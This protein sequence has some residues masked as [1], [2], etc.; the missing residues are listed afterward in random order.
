MSERPRHEPDEDDVRRARRGDTD[1]LERLFVRYAADLRAVVDREGS[2][3]LRNEVR[4]SD[5]L[6]STYIAVLRDIDRFEGVSPRAFLGWAKKILLNTIR[7]KGRYFDLRRRHGESPSPT[8]VEI[9]DPAPGP[10]T[11]AEDEDE[12]RTN[13]RAFQRLSPDHREVLTLAVLEELSHKEIGER[14]GRSEGASAKLLARARAE[15]QIER[16]RL[17]R[18]GEG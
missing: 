15:L 18:E 4:T 8:P 17:R 13:M 9:N 5:L 6:Q 12:F 7:D 11:R 14:M 10:R 1:A 2:P 3:R 16:R